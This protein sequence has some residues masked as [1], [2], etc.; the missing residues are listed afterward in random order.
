VSKGGG[1]EIEVHNAPTV[2]AALIE[3]FSVVADL[4]DGDDDDLPEEVVDAWISCDAVLG[5]HLQPVYTVDP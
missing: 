1:F 3:L 5:E 2:F 4:V